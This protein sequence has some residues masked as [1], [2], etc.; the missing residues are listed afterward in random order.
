MF[1]LTPDPI[2]FQIGPFPVHWYGI[3]YAVGLTAVYF[4]V[5]WLARRAGRNADLVNN[6]IIIVAAAALL[7][8][9]L[10]HVIDQWHLYRDNPAS[11]FL[12][13]Y[14]GLGV[15]GGIATGTLAGWWYFVVRHREPFGVW[16]DIIAPGLFV[17]QSIG[18]W[19]NFFNQEL[20]GPPTTLPW[21]IP[22]DCA[23][24]VAQ[25]S[26]DTLP[27]ATTRFHPLFLYESISGAL[28]ALFL[29]FLFLRYRDRLRPGSLLM[30]FFIWY[31]VVRFA[32]EALRQNNWIVFGI[33]TAQIVSAI[34]IAVGVVGL[35]WLNRPRSASD[36][37]RRRPTDS[38]ASDLPPPA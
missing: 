14:S 16:A 6:A 19:G 31:G 9:R 5:T 38:A 11:I 29:V 28:G 17:M 20:Y 1:D 23:H 13:P 35:V 24:R 33:P 3:A 36:A 22:I 10:Y 32:L 26:C 7:G 12:P 25:F 21:G 30:I 2:A 37:S 15:Y 18:R 8:G 27:E 4:V 34:V